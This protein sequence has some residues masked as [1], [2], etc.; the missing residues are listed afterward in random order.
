MCIISFSAVKNF[1]NPAK[2]QLC[3]VLCFTFS[4]ED[5]NELVVF[6]FLS[7]RH[8]IWMG[9]HPLAS[10]GQEDLEMDLGLRGNQFL[11]ERRGFL[12]ERRERRIPP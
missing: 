3:D 1:L 2:N 8:G 11:G 10:E 12:G 7:S 9:K 6:S 4:E 5:I